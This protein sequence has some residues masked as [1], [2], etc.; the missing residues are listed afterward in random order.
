MKRLSI[1]LA[2]CL[3]TSVAGAAGAP[4]VRGGGNGIFH[5]PP[6]NH[7]VA[8]T[9]AGT[10]L[11]LV[12][13]ELDDTGPVSGDWDINFWAIDSATTLAFFLVS[14]YNANVVV[15][16]DGNAAVLQP[17]DTVGAASTFSG[18]GT[19]DA[20][21]AWL[22]GADGYLGIRF[23]CDGRLANPVPTT[24]CFGYIH[25]VSGDASGFPATIVEY[26][27]D[28]DG[29]DIVVAPAGP[30]VPS[31][32]KSFA[33]A[34][35][36]TGAASTLTIT[37]T[38]PTG[39]AAALTADLVD[40]FPAGLVVAATP[41]ASTTCGGAL[42]ANAGD[43]AATLGAAGSTIPANGACTIAVDVSSDAAGA[44]ANTIPAGALQ[45]DQG[46]SAVAANATLTVTGAPSATVTPASLTLSAPA[47]GSD[48]A[49]L[50]I[51]NAA[52]SSDLTF[53]ITAQ[54][55]SRPLLRP[56]L[57][58]H[59]AAKKVLSASF[60]PIVAAKLYG[61][62]LHAP[63]SFTA[64]RRAHR[65]AAPWA[66]AGSIQFQLDDGTAETAISLNDGVTQT[67]SAYLNRFSIAPGTG[68]FTIDSISIFWP[69]ADMASGDLTGKSV[70][71][72]AY[73][74]ADG[75]GDPANA[76]RLGADAPA[77]IGT[78]GSVETYATSFS[79]PGDG[80][81]YIGFEDSYAS[82]PVLFSTAMDQDASEQ[83][84]YVAGNPGSAIPPDLDDLGNNEALGVIDDITAGG[85]TGNWM[86]R[87]TG[88][89]GGGGPCTGEVVPWLIAS[90]SGGT[91]AGGADTDV[92][93]R[94][95]PADGSLAAGDYTAELCIATNDPAQP[96]VTIPVSLTVT[97]GDPCNAADTILCDGFDG[98][99]GDED[100]VTG[101]IDQPVTQDG[102][103]SSFDFPS[104]DYHPYDPGISTD[105]INLYYLENPS[106]GNPGLLVY[107]YGDAVPAEF[108]DLVGGVVVTEGGT[109][110][111]VLHSG[112]TVG[113][114]SFVSAASISMDNWFETTDGYVGVAFYNEGTGAVNY[115]YIHMT[116][117][118]PEGFPAQVLEYGYNRV[119]DPITIP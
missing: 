103:G 101:T 107:W 11:N 25:F 104:G 112:D 19:V 26:S 99:S 31:A 56:H 32:S 7:A 14:D 44:Y 110:F 45:T 98:S 83:R 92:T 108:A 88:A 41:N 13:G 16:G 73:Y 106:A 55:A 5:S 70:N 46:D 21:D 1:A 64:S 29:N 38:N 87:A 57:R 94:A 20:S 69:D 74:D 18:T 23:D 84:S 4:V 82:S 91:V 10:T 42:T 9:F 2:A 17:G 43:G 51:A 35:V 81:V 50:N 95:T 85:L 52:G 58:S 63:A 39:T 48:T 105:D 76:V 80:D 62:P 6:L 24:S 34:S 96:V 30:P 12:S 60:D 78:P 49:T 77:T 100:V 28:G 109:D 3:A 36:A 102:D 115:G 72:L 93:I 54:S 33:P 75:D 90:P 113:P 89:N 66:P 65:A 86:I 68:A 59:A 114:D 22:A 111:A 37:L 67:P 61:R 79:V 71:L 8:Q 47:D 97:A 117:T 53:A 118:S 27:Y 40:T 119:G 15:D 116:T